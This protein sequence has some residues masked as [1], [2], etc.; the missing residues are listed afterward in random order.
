MSCKIAGAGLTAPELPGIC[1][2]CWHKQCCFDG[3]QQIMTC[4]F[5]RCLVCGCEMNA[6]TAKPITIVFVE[7]NPIVL[8]A[9]RARLQ[10]ER[11]HVE[12]ARDGL[13]AMKILSRLVPDVVILDLMLPKFNGVEVLKFIHSTPLLKAVPIIILS[14]NSII[15]AAEERVLERAHKRLIKGSCTP[16]IVV[17][18]IRELLSGD[19]TIR[20]DNGSQPT[21]SKAGSVPANTPV[22]A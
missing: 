3:E 7:D 6:E 22:N 16:A 14:T 18:A 20:Q 19:P 12:P 4:A 8:A 1:F 2:L 21:E 10:R 17:E 11:F 9:Y 15:D 5:K 13:E